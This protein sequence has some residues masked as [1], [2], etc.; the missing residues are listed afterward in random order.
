MEEIKNLAAQGAAIEGGAGSNNDD[1][2]GLPN[3][4]NVCL[5]DYATT[6]PAIFLTESDTY[7]V[8]GVPGS[9]S[10]FTDGSPYM[11]SDDTRVDRI[12]QIQA[13]AGN[14]PEGSSGIDFFRVTVTVFWKEGSKVTSVPL[15]TY[16]N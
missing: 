3:M 6:G 12:T 13:V 15:T 2:W 7:A 10:T 11:Q 8:Q 4:Q 9:L 16:I 1:F 5:K 14:N